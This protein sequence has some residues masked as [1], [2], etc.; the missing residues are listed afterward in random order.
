MNCVNT[1]HPLSDAQ[2]GPWLRGRR[3]VSNGMLAS[4]KPKWRATVAAVL[5]V[6]KK[7]LFLLFREAARL[8]CSVGVHVAQLRPSVGACSLCSLAHKGV[9]WNNL[10]FDTRQICCECDALSIFGLLV[11][12]GLES[13]H[14]EGSAINAPSGRLE[15]LGECHAVNE[16]TTLGP[17]EPR[18]DDRLPHVASEQ[19]LL[20]NDLEDIEIHPSIIHETV[21]TKSE[22]PREDLNLLPGSISIP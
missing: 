15:C 4:A 1:P 10:D 16:Q 19:C 3:T 2:K 9:E 22:A 6:L 18:L 20:A 12:G 5:V 8:Q 17:G 7:Q 13:N 11:H 21:L 14:R